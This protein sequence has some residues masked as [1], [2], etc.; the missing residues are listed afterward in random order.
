MD[1]IIDQQSSL[2]NQTN[3]PNSNVIVMADTISVATRNKPITKFPDNHT[4]EILNF[5]NKQEAAAQPT[6]VDSSRGKSSSQQ[7]GNQ[8]QTD[9]A[10]VERDSI[11]SGSKYLPNVG[12]YLSEVKN[13]Y[14]SLEGLF[15][16]KNSSGLL[17]SILKRK[18]AS[19]QFIK[20]QLT[21]N[22]EL[23]NE[24]GY[25]QN[26]KEQ[27][28]KQQK[29]QKQQ[30]TVETK[31]GGLRERGY[32]DEQITKSGL[33]EQRQKLQD[34]MVKISPAGN[35]PNTL[36]PEDE[37]DSD[38][39][40]KDKDDSDDGKSS[41]DRVDDIGTSEEERENLLLMKEQNVSLKNIEQYTAAIPALIAAIEG[42]QGKQITDQT[43]ATTAQPTLPDLGVGNV[44]S[45]GAKSIGGSIL[46]GGANLVTKMGGPG[47]LLKAGGLAAGGWLLGSA[48]EVGGEK[49]KESGYEKTGK[50][51]S[52]GGSALKYAGIG[53]GIGSLIPGAGT[54]AGAA[55]GGIVGA[56]VGIYDQYFG[57]E[58]EKADL[59]KKY[60]NGALTLPDGTVVRYS[61]EDGKYTLNDAPVT[62]DTF[63]SFIRA[64]EGIYRPESH[65]AYKPVYEKIIQKSIDEN[66]GVL[67]DATKVEAEQTAKQAVLNNVSVEVSK[68][69]SEAGKSNVVPFPSKA[70]RQAG[71][72]AP[73]S[74][75]V[76]TPRTSAQQQSA[77]P[78]TKTTN[79]QPNQT[80]QQTTSVIPSPETSGNIVKLTPTPAASNQVDQVKTST[81]AF[82]ETVYKTSAEVAAA[83]TQ[84]PAA[85]PPVVVNAPSTNV[86]NQSTI[87][88][89]PKSARNSESSIQQYNRS[90]FF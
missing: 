64:V 76:G 29:I 34:E 33:F 59:L 14:T 61:S 42:M 86:S 87:S 52:V 18:V 38:S 70:D 46:R 49:L 48:V 43:G 85:A 78:T 32:S 47:A 28:N 23:A 11:L 8:T 89:G 53:A 9:N 80:A 15:D 65:P 7:S 4:A 55:I 81:S 67:D 68:I 74:N 84:P 62:K 50:A 5:P 54:V 12:E 72:V 6:A 60:T 17:G 41:S 56:G 13:K 90:R 30:Q 31:I 21:L 19:N 25:K 83:K 37:S 2:G 40:S 57:E 24:P 39:K 77:T 35:L 22:P 66:D 88:S 1:K 75:A 69:I 79:T 36:R 63:E 45:R 3:K 16:V 73:Q 51:V 20:D 44:L 82:G 71:Q 27:F 58:G 10:R 26:L